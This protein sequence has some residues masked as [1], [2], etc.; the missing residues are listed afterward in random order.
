MIKV[1]I[2][3]AFAAVALLYLSVKYYIGTKVLA[4]WIGKHGLHPTKEELDEIQSQVWKN[5]FKRR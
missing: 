1:I 3:L 4:I 5:I 2:A